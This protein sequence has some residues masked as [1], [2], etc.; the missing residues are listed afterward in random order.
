MCYRYARAETA[1]EKLMCRVLGDLLV[2]GYVAKLVNDLYIGGNDIETLTSTWRKVLTT[3]SRANLR[4][5]AR[6]TTIR[7]KKT[8]ILGW[9]LSEGLLV[10]MP[11]NARTWHARS[12]HLYMS[13]KKLLYSE[14]H[15]QKLSEDPQPP[16]MERDL[17]RILRPQTDTHASPTRHP[18]I[19]A[20]YPHQRREEVPSD[21]HCDPGWLNSRPSKQPSPSTMGCDRS[22][23]TRPTCLTHSPPYQTRA[24]Y[25]I[26]NASSGDP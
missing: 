8:S 21:H 26:P 5:S 16:C 9:I 11:Q 2:E 4:L 17:E 7:P 6:K 13:R 3:L 14:L 15:R 19:E 24:P 1:L 23:T 25:Q 20:T 10:A 22:P 12:A 18:S